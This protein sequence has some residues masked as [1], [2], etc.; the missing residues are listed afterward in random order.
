MKINPSSKEKKSILN[1]SNSYEGQTYDVLLHAWMGKLTGWLSPAA[2]GLST[3]DWL[4]HLSIAPVKQMNLLQRGWENSIELYLTYLSCLGINLFDDEKLV[5]H[6]PRENDTRFKG[7]GWQQ[8]PF[9]FYSDAFLLY[10][11]MVE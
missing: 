1:F 11:K 8:F 9:N 7:E 5:H 3:Y 2:L 6:K 4:A 10:E